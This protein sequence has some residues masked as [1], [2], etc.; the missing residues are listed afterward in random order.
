MNQINQQHQPNRSRAQ[1]QASPAQAQANL[2]TQ[3]QARHIAPAVLPGGPSHIIY[4]T[5]QPNM[6]RRNRR[7]QFCDARDIV[8][9]SL[10]SL[11]VELN[12]QESTGNPIVDDLFGGA[13]FYNDKEQV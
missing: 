13:S 7:R 10:P 6:S 9:P 8:T 1:V 12:P 4:R 3:H 11:M 2:Q 5:R